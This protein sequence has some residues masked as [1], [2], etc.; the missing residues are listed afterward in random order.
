MSASK[1]EEEPEQLINL[2]WKNSNEFKN[3][4]GFGSLVSPEFTRVD[5]RYQQH[6]V[7]ATICPD[8]SRHN[9]IILRDTGA[10]QSLV[11]SLIVTWHEFS[12]AK[13]V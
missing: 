12:L 4:S 13:N 8:N 11:P 7:T 2:S 5:P 6:C 1:S 10:L 3:P 9:V